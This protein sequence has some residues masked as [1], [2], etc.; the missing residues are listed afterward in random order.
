MNTRSHRLLLG[1]LSSMALAGAGALVACTND[2]SNGDRAGFDPVDAGSDSVANL[3]DPASDAGGPDADADAGEQ[4]G[5]FDP[6][7]EPVTCAGTGPCA[8]QI[9]AGANH[10]CALLSDGTV[11][12]W[13]D[14]DYGALGGGDRP[15]DPKSDDDSGASVTTTVTGLT[16]VTQI[17]AGRQSTCARRADGNVW[18]W[19]RNTEGQLGLGAAKPSWDGM[20][21]P[22]AM[23]VALY[24]AALRVDVGEQNACAVLASGKVSCWGTNERAQLARPDAELTI[25]LGPGSA[26]L[27]AFGVTRI[28]IGTVTLFGVTSTKRVVDWGE[29][30]GRDGLL[31]GRM[32]SISPDPFANEIP[33]LED[34]TSI[35]ATSSRNRPGS[36]GGFPP[37]PPVR[38]AHACAIAAGEVHCW[39]RSDVGALC[40]G[41]PDEAVEPVL[42]PIKGKAWPQ[43]L[44]VGHEITCARMTDGSIHCCGG[45]EKGRLGAGHTEPYAALFTRIASFEKH[46]VQ[47][48]T[49]DG[50]VCALV[51]DGSVECWGSNVFGE[52]ATGVRDDEPHPTPVKVAF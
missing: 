40:T 46:A 25:V 3:P 30:A 33:S 14:D 6:K 20:P 5:A 15:K 45:A 35:A 16:N 39:G 52:L 31:G 32:T 22:T 49:S 21:H 7:D 12:C 26:E 50:A 34:V 43:Q 8:V 1:I 11:R 51:K 19:G 27:D 42:A 37:K 48:A 36:G 29:I 9:V 38:L 4:R 17:S 10:F 44:A 47:V 23:P 18:C 41:L 24:A 13:G 2:A 28:A